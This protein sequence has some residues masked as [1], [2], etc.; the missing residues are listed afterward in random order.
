MTIALAQNLLATAGYMHRKNPKMLVEIARSSNFTRGISNRLSASSRRARTLGMI[1]AVAISQLVDT[2]EKRIKFEID[3]DDQSELEWYRSL[4]QLE[5]RIG[6]MKELASFW[7]TLRTH[8]P[9][10]TEKV[11]TSKRKP[12]ATILAPKVLPAKVIEIVEPEGDVENEL[13]PYIKPDSDPEDEDED[14]T[15]VN[16]NKPRAP[17]YVLSLN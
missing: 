4:T 16:R 11:N 17:M 3:A 8:E 15:L 2:P 7:G 10:K 6:D 12:N 5:D 1:V 13:T 9:K 14:P